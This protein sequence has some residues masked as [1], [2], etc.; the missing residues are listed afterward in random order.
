MFLGCGQYRRL[1]ARTENKHWEKYDH[2]IRNP[3]LERDGAS[4]EFSCDLKLSLYDDMR[5]LISPRNPSL[6]VGSR[7]GR[8]R[9]YHKRRYSVSAG[10][11]NGVQDCDVVIVGGGP[12]GL[13]FA[14]ALVSHQPIKQSLRIALVE[15]SDLDRVRQWS[16]SENAFSN[17]VSSITNASRKFLGDTGA[18]DN[19]E[20]SRVTR[21]EEMQVWDGVSDARINFNASDVGFGY[22]NGQAPHMATMAENLNLQRALLR[23]LETSGAVEIM[24]KT[25]VDSIES[26]VERGG[27]PLVHTS[28]GGI[29]RARLLVGADGPNSPV[30]S[31]AGI[32]SYGWAYDTRAI[33][34]T[35]NHAPRL[36]GLQTPNTTAYQRFLPTG[37]IAFLP[38]SPTASSMVWS[39]KPSLATA[40]AAVD[41]QV[42]VH[43]INAAFRLPEVSMRHL[44]RIMLEGGEQTSPEALLDEIRWRERS[45]DIDQYSAYSSLTS[46]AVGIPP[47]DAESLPPVVTSIQPG[48][49]ASFPLRL[50]H[51]D[52]YIGEGE[53]GSRT[54][55]LGDA[56]HTIHPLAGQGLNMGLADAQSLAECIYSAVLVGGDIG[57]RT[58]LLPYARGRYFENHKL[59]S[60]T[61]KLHKL[62]SL[63]LPP[64]VWARSVGL[65]VVNELDALKAAVMMS[66]GSSGTS[67]V[68][69]FER[70]ETTPWAAAARGVELVGS[71]VDSAGLVGRTVGGVM[72]TG[73]NNLLNSAGRR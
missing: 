37:P 33:V 8:A 54:V 73:L 20:E 55:L 66:A 9:F 56:A 10:A 39:T 18:W 35:L 45:H 6:K 34:A 26:D 3:N 40:L 19:V 50:T 16:L 25:K 42:L 11:H 17:R 51:A 13:A 32:E 52:S 1:T 71:V 29:L 12:A 49:V 64:V 57:S 4:S 5:L 31:Y 63:T 27:W 22:N 67:T 46:D 58:T 69:R 2:K 28:N 53:R 43:M 36:P 61:D 14:N 48:T 68:K 7:V 70:Q 60:V 24:D 47:I 21:I 41:P 38:L 44:H 59:L 72:A 23:S 65:E 15:A 30:R 62:Y